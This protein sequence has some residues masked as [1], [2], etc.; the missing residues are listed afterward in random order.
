MFPPTMPLDELLTRAENSNAAIARA[1]QEVKVQQ[2][3]TALFRA[4]RIPNLGLEFGLDLNSPHDFEV[5]GRGQVSME[6]PLFSRYQGEIA[7]SL[8]GERELEGELAAARRAADARVES[9]YFD[10]EARRTQVQLYR[11]TILPSSRRFEEIAEESYRAGATNILT[12]LS[13]QHDVQQTESNYLD[14]L[15]AAQTAFAQLEEAVGAP[16]E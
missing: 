4:D 7:E 15:Q 12:V 5:G 8:A 3:Q 9:A 1:S 11:D 16:L 14:S 10:L 6:L 13:A 2:S